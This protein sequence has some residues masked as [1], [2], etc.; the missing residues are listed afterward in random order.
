MA[1]FTYDDLARHY[2]TSRSTFYRHLNIQIK[3]NKFVK[4]SIG[5]SFNE[6]DAKKISQLLGFTIPELTL[7]ETTDKKYSFK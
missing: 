7:N 2:G 4:T 1:T 3:L 5:D 6:L